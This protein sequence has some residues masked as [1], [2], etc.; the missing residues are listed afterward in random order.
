V[1]TLFQSIPA[2]EDVRKVEPGEGDR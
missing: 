1:T 2:I